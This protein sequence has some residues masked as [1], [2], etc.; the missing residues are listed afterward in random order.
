MSI[1]NIYVLD[2]SYWY[3]FVI[4]Y[5]VLGIFMIFIKQLCF[6]KSSPGFSIDEFELF[7]IDN[8]LPSRSLF[9]TALP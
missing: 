1:A 2:F 6:K 4:C 9:D 8:P 5:L 7:Q 3:L